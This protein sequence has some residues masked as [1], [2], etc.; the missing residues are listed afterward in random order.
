[1]HPKYILFLILI[2]RHIDNHYQIFEIDAPE[3]D[4][5]VYIQNAKNLRPGQLVPLKS[6]ALKIMIYK[7]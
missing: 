7:Q 2:I 1:M 4:G 3:I 5:L 6:L